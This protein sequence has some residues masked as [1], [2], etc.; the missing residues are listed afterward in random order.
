MR[1][2]LKK[3]KGKASGLL[4][5]YINRHIIFLLVTVIFSTSCA[6]SLIDRSDT[7]KKVDQSIAQNGYQQGLNS[8]TT[9]QNSI[10]P[11][12]DEKNAISL[13]LDKGLLEHYDGDYRSST[14][15][16]QYAERLI[17]EA[18]TKSISESVASYILNDN[19]KEYPGEDFEDI[20]LSVFNAL[21]YYH[22]GNTE[23]ALVEVRKLTL[24]NHK[25][26]MLSRKYEK[27]NAS[28]RQS[29][30][31]P[32]DDAPAVPNVTFTNSALA[33]YLSVIFYQAER[34]ED[35]ARIELQQ[36]Q[37][38]YTSQPNIYRN[39]LP[40]AVQTITNSN[41]TRLDIMCFTGLSPIKE[42]REEQFFY[43]FFSNPHL[44]HVRV[45]LPAL[46][47]R[48]DR[49]D[50]IEI[51]VN[52]QNYTLE[53]LEDI[54]AVIADTFNARYET[55]ALKTYLRT[56]A[57]YAAQEASYIA[58]ERNRQRDNNSKDDSPLARFGRQ[59]A[60]GVGKVLIDITERA[61][62]RMSRYLPSKVYI[63]SIQIQPGTYDI[64]VRYYSRG[65]LIQSEIKTCTVRANNVNLVQLVN[66]GI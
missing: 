27:V 39:P 45:K 48:P 46:V 34:N 63:G 57:K 65:A 64:A 15:S 23:G 44:M 32:T 38:A 54:S 2:S 31:Y 35:A 25:L 17:E 30:E 11:L 52:G 58:I 37:A 6:T 8:I 60:Y 61:D 5:K 40:S 42:E 18:F 49:I 59:F 9:A 50:K 28:A 29:S 55:I 53:L 47:N 41:N 12:Y 62:V 7:Y 19:T 3:N 21:N 22:L 56:L 1:A 13:Y 14:Q 20:Y 33:R 4:K 16:L 26:D 43:P 24:P 51:D 66:L 10:I 36:L